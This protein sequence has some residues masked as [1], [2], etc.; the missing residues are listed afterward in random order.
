MVY[1]FDGHYLSPLKSWS[2]CANGSRK[3]LVANGLRTTVH[4]HLK[5]NCGLCCKWLVCKHLGQ[6]LTNRGRAPVGGGARG[7]HHTPS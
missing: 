1:D 3:W 2:Y 6:I 4:S 7:T 5:E